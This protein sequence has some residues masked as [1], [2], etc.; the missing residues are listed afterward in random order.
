MVATDDL[1]ITDELV[2]VERLKK[3]FPVTQGLILMK[4]VGYVQAVDGIS[5]AIRQGETL[6]LVGESGCGKTTTSKL[7][8]RLERPTEGSV[9]LEGRDI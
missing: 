2:R 9:L 7:I 8:L 5:F 1:V 4:T 3:Y 6:G